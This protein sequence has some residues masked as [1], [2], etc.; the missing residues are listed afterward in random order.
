MIP[1]S[2]NE[3]LEKYGNQSSPELRS[4]GLAYGSTGTIDREATDGSLAA[5]CP[6]AIIGR[7][8]GVLWQLHVRRF[9]VAG[10]TQATGTNLRQLAAWILSGRE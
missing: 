1:S 3:S 8:G 5:A 9:G 2:T 4:S 10:G 7:R 6:F